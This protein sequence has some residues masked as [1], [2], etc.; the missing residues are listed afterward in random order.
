MLQTNNDLIKQTIEEYSNTV[1]RICL[2]YMRNQLDAEDAFQEIFMKIIEKAPRFNDD[3][4]K[5]AWI[6]TVASN[7]CKNL[8]KKKKYRITIEFNENYL[9]SNHVDEGNDLLHTIMTLPLNYR[10]VIYLYYYEGYSTKEISNI[11]N[12]RDATIRTWLKRARE[13]LKIMIGG[14]F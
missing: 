5:K 12:Q 3:E 4:H 8:L 11:L 2:M 10:N 1:F 7:H 13:S 6:I 14:C 9:L